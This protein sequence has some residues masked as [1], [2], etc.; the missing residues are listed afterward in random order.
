M[1]DAASKWQDTVNIR[2]RRTS[3]SAGLG[4]VCIALLLLATSIQA[5]HIC[6]FRILGAPAVA[7]ARLVPPSAVCLTC[8]MAQS[9]AEAVIFVAFFF[10]LRCSVGVWPPQMRPR[11]FLEFF[12]LYVRPPPAC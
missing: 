1:R 10:T 6:G 12:R 9:S 5:A 4:Y 3:W 7:Q 8:L 11:P 2:R